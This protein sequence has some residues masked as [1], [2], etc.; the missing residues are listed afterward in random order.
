MNY[1]FNTC[2]D[3]GCGTG[4]IGIFLLKKNI[5]NRTVFIDIS[6][7]ALGNTLYN[8]LLNKVSHK[9][10]LVNGEHHFLYLKNNSF[11]LI[12]SNPPYLP[13]KIANE[14]DRSLIGGEHGYETILFFIRNSYKL[15]RDKG[16]FFITYSTLSKADVVEN[17]LSK[18]FIVK[19]K[20]SKRFFY[21][22][23]YIVRAEK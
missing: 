8:V 10:L 13:G 7:K 22:T 3:L 11:D 12:V 1:R 2:I 6:V 4:I 5:C 16:I 21:E 18:Y 19:K 20:Y 15:L 9:S 17:E 14:Y 23:I